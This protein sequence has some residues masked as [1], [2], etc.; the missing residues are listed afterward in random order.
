MGG[1]WESTRLEAGTANLL[2]CSQELPE[3]HPL[4]RDEKTRTQHLVMATLQEAAAT[5][6]NVAWRKNWMVSGSGRSE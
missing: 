1:R 6:E 2:S 3:Q 5:R 4:H